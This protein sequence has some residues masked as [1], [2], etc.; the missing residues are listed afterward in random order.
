MADIGL[1][2]YRFSVAWPRVVPT[3]SGEV[4]QAGLDF[5]RRLADALL[6]HGITP[7]ATL[8][9]WDLPQALQDRGGWTN[10]ETAQRLAAS[11]MLPEPLYCATC[12]YGHSGRVRSTLPSSTS[13]ALTYGWS[14]SPP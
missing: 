13:A 7:L 8:Y 6:E 5:Y 3:G 9:H 10:R 1:G 2:S 12:G 14:G 11:S 4:N